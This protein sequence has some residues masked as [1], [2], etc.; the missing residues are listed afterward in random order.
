M[1]D[2]NR[3]PARWSPNREEKWEMA[4]AE[5]RKGTLCVVQIIGPRRYQAIEI[6][7]DGRILALNGFKEDGKDFWDARC[8]FWDA[9]CILQ[10]YDANTG[11]LTDL[12]EMT[13]DLRG[14]VTLYTGSFLSSSTL[15]NALYPG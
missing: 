3:W 2:D 6:L 10:L 14:L 5:L 15:S 11:T 1:E 13:L 12:M 9:R 4:L 7:G 8:N